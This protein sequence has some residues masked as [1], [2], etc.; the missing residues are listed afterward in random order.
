M[1]IESIISIASDVGFFVIIATE[2]Y[3]L[4]FNFLLLNFINDIVANKRRGINQILFTELR[5]KVLLI[6]IWSINLE[7]RYTLSQQIKVSW[8]NPNILVI[9]IILY[10]ILIIKRLVLA[11]LICISIKLNQFLPLL[12]HHIDVCML[13]YLLNVLVFVSHIK[14]NFTQFIDLILI[15]FA[16]HEFLLLLFGNMTQK[17]SRIMEALSVVHIFFILKERLYSL[18]EFLR[19]LKDFFEF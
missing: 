18:F 15:H 13:G 6:L 4:A 1:C 2:A 3:L 14:L 8:S 17:L 11:L 12:K 5:A 7:F 9:K 16:N 10:S 19:F